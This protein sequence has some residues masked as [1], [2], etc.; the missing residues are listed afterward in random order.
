VKNLY[1]LLVSFLLLWLSNCPVLYLFLVSLL[2][3]LALLVSL[4]LLWRLLQNLR[5][6]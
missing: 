4:W 6:T 1:L 3:W 5:H 2:L